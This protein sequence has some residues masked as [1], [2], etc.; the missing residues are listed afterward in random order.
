MVDLL[1]NDG[2]VLYGGKPMGRTR[3]NIIRALV[4]KGLQSM[5][6]RTYDSLSLSAITKYDPPDNWKR[7]EVW[8]R[9]CKEDLKPSNAFQDVASK[10]KVIAF[11]GCHSY[12]KGAWTFI[13]KLIS[14]AETINPSIKLHFIGSAC[15]NDGNPNFI[16]ECKTLVNRDFCVMHQW[17][18][19]DED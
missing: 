18:M 6:Y 7:D 2:L 8:E 10:S 3:E 9:I 1:S 17:G 13:R 4:Q 16:N 5:N 12:T 15:A 11:F 14:D 19:H